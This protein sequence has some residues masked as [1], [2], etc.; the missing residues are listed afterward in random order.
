MHPKPQVDIPDHHVGTRIQTKGTYNSEI[1]S[2][3][4]QGYD[5]AVTVKS[6]SDYNLIL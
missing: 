4:E 6:W 3:K 2:W 5:N 1:R